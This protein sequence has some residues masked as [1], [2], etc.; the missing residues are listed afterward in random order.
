MPTYAYLDL[1]CRKNVLNYVW[2]GIRCISQVH[3]PSRTPIEILDVSRVE[4]YRCSQKHNTKCVG[5]KLELIWV[6]GVSVL[7]IVCTST[8]YLASIVEL[9]IYLTGDIHMYLVSSVYV[10]LLSVCTRVCL[11]WI[12]LKHVHILYCGYSGKWQIPRL[13]Y[14]LTCKGKC[15]GAINSNKSTIRIIICPCYILYT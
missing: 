2:A 6:E 4:L 13:T 15:V 14:N 5:D 1:C 8:K 11:L 7:S 9:R 12:N 3:W 10:Q